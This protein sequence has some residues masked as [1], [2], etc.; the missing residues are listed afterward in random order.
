[1]LFRSETRRLEG[2][3]LA[4]RTRDGVPA[5]MLAGDELA[6]LVERHGSRVVLTPAGRLL[7]N[8]ISMRLR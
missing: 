2:L 6:G 5:D 1:M 4:L 3:Q 8:E 7:A